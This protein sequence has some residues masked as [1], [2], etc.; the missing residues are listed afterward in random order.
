M[1]I[2]K[3]QSKTP[4]AAGQSLIEVLVAI[5]IFIMLISALTSLSLSGLSMIEA[6]EKSLKA[7]CLMR[8]GMEGVRGVK[9]TAW[10]ELFYGK[11]VI[12]I[13]GQH[14]GL[15]RTDRAEQIDGYERTIELIPVFRDANGGITSSASPGAILDE[16]SI[17]ARIVIAWR[18]QRGATSTLEEEA[19]FANWETETWTQTDWSGGAGRSLW[20][21]SGGYEMDDGGLAFS[22]GEVT[23]SMISSSTYKTSGYLVSSAYDASPSTVFMAI[24]WTARIPE[25]CQECK[26]QFLVKTA[27]DNE[28]VPS[29]WTSTWSGPE[30]N[31]GDENDF[32]ERAAGN[33]I[34]PD[35]NGANWIKY[36][37]ILIGSG[38]FSPVLEEV[39]IYHK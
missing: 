38:S 14:L 22:S 10:N 1:K 8:E 11:A 7:E 27:P 36:K 16:Q 31:D 20:A 15:L 35:H 18:N 9:E 33:I 30:G 4:E 17:K 24:E 39:R 37:A 12:D 5:A 13:S 3:R 32:F 6:S 19:N 25:G 2:T 28:A 21:D 26:I 34:H 23:L 29:D